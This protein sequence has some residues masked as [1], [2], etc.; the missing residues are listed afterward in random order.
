MTTS[1]LLP[2]QAAAA[3][4]QLRASLRGTV[5]AAGD[6][7]YDTARQVW[8]GA[9]DHRP[10]LIARCQDGKDITAA[11]RAAREHALPLSVRGGGHDWAGRA[12]R[13]GGLVLDLSAMRGVTVDPA[14]GTAVA[15]GGATAG[16]VVAAA[17]RY[18]LAP[19]TG[20]VKA[21]GMAGLTLAGGY[22]PL[23][24]KHGLALDN[25]L[26]ADVV[27]ADG[28]QVTASDT[29]DSDLYWALRGGGGTFGVVTAARYRLH[30][31]PAILAG[32]I[33]FP[34]GQADAVL[35]GYAEITAAGPDELTVM[36]GFLSAGGQMLLF[37]FPTWSGDPGRG[38]DAITALQQLG[39]PVMAQVAPDALR[40]CPGH[41]RPKRGQR[42][43]LRP[44][45][46]AGCPASPTTPPRCSPPQ[47]AAPPRRCPRSRYTT[48]TAPQHAVPAQHTAFALRRDH[49]LVEILAAWEPSPDAGPAEH[50]AWAD[51]L[52]SQLAPSA[53]PGGYPN[54]LGPGEP[55][56]V[57]LAYG[58]N[59]PRLQDLKHRYDPD[60]IFSTATGTL[61]AATP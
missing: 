56:R 29:S 31:L 44:A 2:Q 21:V 18:G 7:P 20:T 12:L 25:L 23:C 34:L 35:R 27:L 46:P 58:P 55:G 3:A 24:G 50:R 28:Q 43:P 13:D 26:G 14:A 9:V 40:R 30:P 1:T 53:L 51:G 6:A 17:A 39:T 59:A 49:L 42:P 61:P 54:L 47:R 11:V 4:R 37:L 10:A 22:G 57:L 48:S 36:A 41:V 19:V 5:L 60:G 45:P 8:N 33:L 15:Q 52:S 38:Q 32:L 16:D